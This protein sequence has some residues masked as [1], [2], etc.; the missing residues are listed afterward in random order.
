MS[1]VRVNLKEESCSRSWTPGSQKHPQRNPR[2]YLGEGGQQ[3]V[4]SGQAGEWGACEH[5]SKGQELRC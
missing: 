1:P 2:G 3:E 4:D 5:L